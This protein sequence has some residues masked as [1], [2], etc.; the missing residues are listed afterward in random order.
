MTTKA[1]MVTSS[2]LP[3]RGGIESYLAELC[4]A[5]SPHVAVMA[6]GTRDGKLLPTDLGYPTIAGRGRMLRPDARLGDLVAAVA[7]AHGTDR[8]LFGTPWPLALLG[9]RLA[10]RGFRYASLAFGAELLVPASIPWLRDRF[11]GALEG[12]DLLLP[13]SD[14]TELRLRSLLG[15]R[16]RTLPPIEVLRARVD[17]DR[18]SPL[19]ASTE[20]RP[21]FG[22]DDA[23]AV[24]LY[25][26]RL[27]R[28]KGVHRLIDVLPDL[29]AAYDRRVVLVIAGG[30]PEERRLRRLA[31]K[32]NAHVVF[33]GRVSDDD[34]PALYAA[35]DVFALPVA[36]RWRG[37]ETEGLG[38]VLLE[39][40]ACATPCVTGRSGGTVEAVVDG[41][42]GY[43][44]DARNRNELVDAISAILTNP[45]EAA[46]MGAAGREFVAQRYPPDQVSEA[47]QRWLR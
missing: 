3:G 43:I 26:G 39:A 4:A 15:R 7:E 13:M 10:R 37:L 6:P 38:V 19:S 14:F 32:T 45:S 35:A 22:L 41:T 29:R 36:D 42:T 21:R 9:P 27:V 30:G 11:T 28:R 5:L 40:A 12:A 2:F 33:A 1:L 20:A 8:I 16:G 46:S 24:V 34:A 25:L 18:F 47:L 44:V 23:D 17:L 31:A